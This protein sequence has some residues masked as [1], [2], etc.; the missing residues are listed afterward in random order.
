MF[1]RM[2]MLNPLLKLLLGLSLSHYK[3]S[4]VLNCARKTKMP[5]LHYSHIY[6]EL[7]FSFWMQL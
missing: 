5:Y 2:I 1:T 4:Y 6:I 3:N 7:N